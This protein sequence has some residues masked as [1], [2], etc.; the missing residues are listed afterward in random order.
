MVNRSIA[1]AWRLP[2]RAQ[3]GSDQ[4]S[5]VVRAT[6]AALL[7]GVFNAAIITVS[8]WPSVSRMPLV[9]WFLATS[10][11][12]LFFYR[13]SHAGPAREA[14]SLS[15]RAMRRAVI[16]ALIMALPWAVVSPMYL[17]RLPHVSELLLITV[18]AGMSSGGSVLLAPVYPAAIAYMAGI[19]GPFA[20]TCL[21]MMQPGY[22]LLGL[23]S[24]SFALFLFAVIATTARL[25]VER[26]EALR[27]LTH[28]AQ[29]LTERDDTISAQ[30][31]RFESALNNMTQ[32]LCFFDGDERLI[33]CNRRYL[34]LYGLNAKRVRP[35]VT[36]GEILDMRI[37]AG[38]ATSLSKDQYLSW[39]SNVA[40]ANGPSESVHT[41]GNGRVYAIRYRPMADGAW[42]ATTDDITEPHRLKEQLEENHSKIAHMATHDALTGLAN[43]V[44]FRQQ[45]DHAVSVAPWR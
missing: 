38:T 3:V 39:R 34:E 8:C 18:L 44:L 15:P 37:E 12:T 23:V 6:P 1:T 7:C 42:V 40:S 17:G 36:L 30:N 31:L 2:D 9:I 33:V 11:I 5:A 16:A 29:Q 43:R 20:I 14:A 10:A 41:L 28:S 13:R 45:L 24:L 21:A 22:L 32:G 19:L 26:T 27:A 4:L 25:S 35:G